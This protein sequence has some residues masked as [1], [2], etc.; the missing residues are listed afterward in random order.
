MGSQRVRHDWAT[1][2]SL[3]FPDFSNDKE[4]TCNV[5]DPGW[6]PGSGRS[7]GG[8]TGYLLQYSWASLVALLVKFPPAMPETWVQFLGWKKSP[9]EGKA[10]H[11]SILTWIPW[12]IQ[13]M[14]LQSQTQLSN[15]YTH[16]HSHQYMTIGKTI[17]FVIWNFAGKVMYLPFN[18]LVCHSSP[19]KGQVS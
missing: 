2:L 4:S 9:G 1:S 15:F 17:D 14:R 11:I 7:T 8:R 3:G 5:G 19:S 12:T 16:I 18:T 10:T 6:I 13:S